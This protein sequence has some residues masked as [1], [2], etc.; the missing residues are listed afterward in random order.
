MYLSPDLTLRERE[1]GRK[2]RE[3]LKRRRDNGEHNLVIRNR[4]IVEVKNDRASKPALT[5]THEGSHS[6]SATMAQTDGKQTQGS[7]GSRRATRII[8]SQQTH[9]AGGQNP[10]SSVSVEPSPSMTH[11]HKTHS[12]SA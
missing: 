8:N 11:E 5:R 7:G 4:K 1:E 2:L 10:G 6:S 3:E 12:E 9:S